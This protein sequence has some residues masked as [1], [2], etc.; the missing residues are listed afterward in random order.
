MEKDL[1]KTDEFFESV[2][3][4]VEKARNF[5]GRT[6]DLAMTISYFTIGKMIVEKEQDGNAR[7]AYGT[8]MIEKLSAYLTQKYKKGFSTTTLKTAR[9]FYVTY[10][11]QI[12]QPLVDQLQVKKSQLLV[13]QFGVEYIKR[14][15]QVLKLSWSHYLILIR[16]DNPEERNFYELEAVNRGWSKR[17]LEREYHSSLYERLALSRDKNKVMELSIKGQVMEQPKDMLKNPLVLEFLGLDEKADYSETDLENAIISKMQTFLLELGKGFLFEA[18]Q[19]R[20]TFD[21]D[22]FFVDLKTEKLKHQDLGQML[23][24]ANYFDRYVKTEEEL[25]TVGIVLCKKGN[26]N[27][28]ELTLP[29]DSNIYASEY[30]LYLP[31]KDLLQSKLAEWIKEFEDKITD[32]L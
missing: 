19:K 4:V 6:T 27:L 13:D 9:Q 2:A 20:F 3:N 24:Y 11:Q 16:I 10:Q 17:D 15:S 12:S 5:I 32:M 30:S 8:K 22:H 29:K 26:K 25:P 18:R 21:N 7:A 23:M 28:V 14:I 1:T 31:D